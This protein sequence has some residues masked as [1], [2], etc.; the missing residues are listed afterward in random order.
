MGTDHV[1]VTGWGFRI[2][3]KLW[4]EYKV[5]LRKEWLANYKKEYENRR[6]AKKRKVDND[7]EW[8][9]ED[10]DE[11]YGDDWAIDTEIGIEKFEECITKEQS[12]LFF[13]QGKTI[14]NGYVFICDRL[15]DD[16][17]FLMHQK[18]GG[19]TAWLCSD[20]E[21]MQN[22]KDL[23]LSI[24]LEYPGAY[25]NWRERFE[26]FQQELPEFV[27]DFLNELPVK[28]YYSRWLFGFGE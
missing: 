28:E 24:R 8:E 1:I 2:P 11:L 12:W 22:V 21:H 20:F 3:L 13:S 27:Q 25:E 18:I 9:S 19:A 17:Q 10:I 7:E 15:K 23:A 14:E 4:E 26:N 5:K 6:E 16:Y